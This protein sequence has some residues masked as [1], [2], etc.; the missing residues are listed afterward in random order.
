MADFEQMRKEFIEKLEKAD[1]TFDKIFQADA[2]GL[3]IHGEDRANLQTMKDENQ[4]MLHKLKSREFSVSIVGLEKAGKSTLGKN[5]IFHLMNGT[6]GIIPMNRIRRSGKGINGIVH[7][8]FWRMYIILRMHSW[9][10]AC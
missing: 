2:D 7:C 6:Y 5:F 10:A 8:R 3:V 4:K 1:A 9:L